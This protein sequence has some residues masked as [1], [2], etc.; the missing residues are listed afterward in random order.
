MMS[1]I[2]QDTR[3][4]I[5]TQLSQQVGIS[6]VTGANNDMS[7]YT[8]SGVTLFQGGQASSVTFQ[9]TTTYTAS[10]TGNAVYIDGIPVTGS[11]ATMPIQ[12][13]ALAGLAN[14][15]DNIAVTYQAQLDQTAQGL[16][17]AFAETN[18]SPPNNALAG[19]FTNAGSTTIPVAG[20][21]Y[22]PCRHNL[23]EC[24]RRPEPG[25]QSTIARQW[26]QFQ[27]Q[28]RQ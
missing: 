27:F 8:D 20:L 18:P 5:L 24:R 2:S 13:G 7:I 21:G 15:R 16:I 23:G 1:P 4:S 12:S 19:L 9:P 14:L 6:T 25:R 3:N 28:H 22:G 11:S 10:T 26:H 17:Q